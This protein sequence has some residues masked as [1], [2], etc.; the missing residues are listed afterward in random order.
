MS[1]RSKSTP[2]VVLSLGAWLRQ[3]RQSRYLP[4]RAVAAEA[5]MDTAHL[6]KIELGQRLPTEEQ[7]KTLA[8]IFNIPREDLAAKRIAEQFWRNHQRK[9]GAKKAAALIKQKADNPT[10][11]EN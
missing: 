8:R 2:E 7:T 4:I 1:S 9:P 11:S 6:S 5:G 10:C 3:L